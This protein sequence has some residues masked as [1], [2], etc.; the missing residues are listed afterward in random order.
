MVHYWAEDEV[1]E[2]SFNN[3]KQTYESYNGRLLKEFAYY[4][5]NEPTLENMRK[6]DQALWTYGHC[7]FVKKAM[8]DI[9]L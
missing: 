6:L 7:Y 5:N 1:P 9:V 4:L 3:M 2:P 8:K